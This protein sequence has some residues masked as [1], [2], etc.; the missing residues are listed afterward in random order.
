L[1]ELT[2][3]GYLWIDD[4]K[5]SAGVNERFDWRLLEFEPY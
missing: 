1:A 4:R 2:C 3:G 5:G